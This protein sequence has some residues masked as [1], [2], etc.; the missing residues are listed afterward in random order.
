MRAVEF[1]EVEPGLGGERR[2][3]REV[4]ANPV[5]VRP[6][7]LLGYLTVRKVG[8]CGG[9]QQRPGPA[10]ERLVHPLPCELGRAL[11]SRV[12]QLHADLGLGTAVDELHDAAPAVH[13]LGAI[14]AGTAG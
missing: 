12:T 10:L 11:A 13:V 14:H 4:V 3:A 7:H 6:V 9:G 2:G 5:H 8:E 1:E